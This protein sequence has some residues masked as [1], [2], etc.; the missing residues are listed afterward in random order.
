MTV[1]VAAGLEGT[2][3]QSFIHHLKLSTTEIKLLLAPTLSGEGENLTK[4][5]QE[6]NSLAGTSLLLV[7]PLA[8][9]QKL[10]ATK[11]MQSQVDSLQH[12]KFQLKVNGER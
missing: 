11:K 10:E 12:Q 5:S 4:L 1:T 8:R 3:H 9:M 2:A 6:D 7:L